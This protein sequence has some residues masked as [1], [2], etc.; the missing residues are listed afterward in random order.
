MSTTEE[1]HHHHHHHNQVDETG[2][3]RKRKLSKIKQKK[4]LSNLLF[5]IMCFIAAI[6]VVV[7][8]WIY[9]TD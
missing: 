4:I 3:Y 6:I 8:I 1:I 9:T 5:T 7:C 2:L